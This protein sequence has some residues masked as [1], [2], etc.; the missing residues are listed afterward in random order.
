MK[1]AQQG[2]PSFRVSVAT[3]PT[4]GFK[5]PLSATEGECV[6][7]A[8]D[9]DVLS[10]ERLHADL[11]FRR[12]RREGVSVAGTLRAAITQSCVVTLEPLA[13][14]ISAEIDRTFLP[15][16]S[17]LTRPRL[18]SEGE[19]ILDPDGRDGPDIFTGDTIDAWEIVLE[20]LYLAIDPFP[21][22]P[23]LEAVEI[24][25][26]RKEADEERHNPFSG[27]KDLLKAKKPD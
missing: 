5:V 20:Q 24:Y 16:G 25:D 10:V 9:A 14:E 13:T 19:M 1:P 7:I 11:V 6:A 18:N 27:L 12:W 3:L 23:G 21:R 26:G 8:A 4:S 17:P 15:D 2:L 22:T